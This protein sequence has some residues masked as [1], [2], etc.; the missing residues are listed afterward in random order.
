M[1]NELQRIIEKADPIN[2]GFVF[3]IVLL[4][5]F[6]FDYLCLK[7]CGLQVYEIQH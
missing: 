1:K 6:I 3:F 4:N 2:G 7:K 5:N